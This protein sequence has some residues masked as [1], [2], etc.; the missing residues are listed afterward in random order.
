MNGI[1]ITRWS[2][3]TSLTLAVAILGGAFQF[4]SD[5]IGG[6]EDEVRDL[7]TALHTEISGL[8]QELRADMRGET[9]V[10][11]GEI[12]VLSEEVRADIGDLREEMGDLREE[13]GDVREEVRQLAELIRARDAASQWPVPQGG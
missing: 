3:G 12:A 10:V 6:V 11:R 9:A 2:L 8:R 5:R 7:R 4:Q 13:V 1:T